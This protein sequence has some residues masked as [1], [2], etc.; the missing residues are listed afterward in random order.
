M[1]TDLNALA[2]SIGFISGSAGKAVAFFRGRGILKRKFRVTKT[3]LAK[4]P[5]PENVSIQKIRKVRTR[6]LLVR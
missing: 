5:H 6:E 2:A 4:I 3:T 1:D